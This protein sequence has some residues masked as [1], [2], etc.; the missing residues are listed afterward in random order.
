MTVAVD[1]FHNLV[2]Q[3]FRLVLTNPGRTGSA[4]ASLTLQGFIQVTTRHVGVLLL[5]SILGVIQVVSDVVVLTR[6]PTK[7]RGCI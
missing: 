1:R 7:L 4:C 5:D 2:L 6:G 3:I